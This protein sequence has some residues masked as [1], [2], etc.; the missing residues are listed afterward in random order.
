MEKSPTT[1]TGVVSGNS[2]LFII[3]LSL[4]IINLLLTV[5]HSWE[6]R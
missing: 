6:V 2:I 3:L 5:L 1:N 4:D